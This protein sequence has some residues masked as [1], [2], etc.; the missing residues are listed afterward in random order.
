MGSHV[1]NAAYLTGDLSRA[2]AA[3]EALVSEGIA[4]TELETNLGAA[5][6]R[7]QAAVA[8]AD[9]DATLAKAQWIDRSTVAW[10][11]GPT[12][13]RMAEFSHLRKTHKLSDGA[14]RTLAGRLR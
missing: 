11:T 13:G 10:K 3:Y 2:I 7:P 8:Q 14:R 9:I 1:A 4:S 6:L 5:Y 12:D